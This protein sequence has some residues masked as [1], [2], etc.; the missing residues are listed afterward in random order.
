M[1]TKAEIAALE[2]ANASPSGSDSA[3]SFLTESQRAALDAALAAK[4][5]AP[6]QLVTLQLRLLFHHRFLSPL[7][8]IP[9]HALVHQQ[10]LLQ[11]R[12]Q[13]L[14]VLRASICRQLTCTARTAQH[15]QHSTRST[16]RAAQH[17]QHSTHGTHS[18]ARTA[19]HL[20]SCCS[21]SQ[22]PCS[23]Q[24]KPPVHLNLPHQHPES[25]QEQTAVEP[26]RLPRP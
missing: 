16:A 22:L 2:E 4:Q 24:S 12:T 20:A 17:A 11:L 21:R 23:M 5:T 3:H 14:F 8:A 6:G 25:F 15:A 13:F 19:W 26:G 18:M 9:C 7:Q 1:R 10:L